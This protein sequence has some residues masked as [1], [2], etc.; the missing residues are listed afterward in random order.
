VN[1]L[2][3]TYI[4]GWLMKKLLASLLGVD[5]SFWYDQ[6]YKAASRT[7]AKKITS[8]EN[9]FLADEERLKLLG[10]IK[11]WKN[12]FSQLKENIQTIK[13]KHAREKYFRLIAKDRKKKIQSNFCIYCGMD[14]DTIDHLIPK[15]RGGSNMPDNL[16][17]ACRFCN[18]EK[19]N[20]TYGEYVAWKGKRQGDTL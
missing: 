4:D 1:N 12:N 5:P 7:L 10:E 11:H 3:L 8:V 17:P 6:G 20:M 9:S 14:A 16:A 2:G 15:S 19:G 13:R 18:L